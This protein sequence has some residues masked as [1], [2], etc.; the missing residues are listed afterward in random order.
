M[1]I[2]EIELEWQLFFDGSTSAGKGGLGVVLI[3]PESVIH[4]KAC[5]LM[6]GCSNNEAEYKALIASLELATKK[7]S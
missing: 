6:Y 3:S 5:K 7:G 4:T 1:M 2:A